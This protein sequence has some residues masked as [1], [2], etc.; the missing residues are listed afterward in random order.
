MVNEE[1]HSV[2]NIIQAILKA[3]KV[4]RMY[5]R[6]NPIYIKTL[7]ELTNRFSEFFDLN[8]CLKLNL[9]KNDIQF[10]TDCV[11]HKEDKYDNLA[12]LFFKDGLREL[13]FKRGLS[14]EEIEGFIN[15]I[16][17]DFD[18]D[19]IEDDIVTLLWEKDFENIRHVADDILLGD[20][21]DYEARAL[22]QVM[23]D[24]ESEPDL[25]KIYDDLAMV[26]EETEKDLSVFQS[27]DNDF[28]SFSAELEIDAR[29]KTPKLFHML[30]EIL[31]GLEMREEHQDIVDCFMKAIEFA[32]RQGNIHEV[33]D[34]QAKLKHLMF[35]SGIDEEAKIY[36]LKILQ[37]ASGHSIIDLIGNMLENG[38]KID[39]DAF[40]GY[41]SYLET[42]A[43]PPLLNILKELK[44]INAR[45]MIIEALASIGKKD[46]S[47]LI[48]GLN[49]PQWY[50]VRNVVHILRKIGDKQTV[51]YILKT[52]QH[53]DIRVKKEAIRTIGEL[54]GAD[55]LDTLK[56]CLDDA[57]IQIRKA[58][59]SA[60]G[61][62]GCQSAKKLLMERISGKDFRNRDFIEKKEY[63]EVLARWKENDVFDFLIDIL[64]R[65]ALWGRA[66]YLETKAG[67]AY[68][69]GLI[70]RKEAVAVLNSFRKAS[71]RLLREFS[72]TALKKIEDGI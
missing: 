18:K 59:L 17:Q 1:T 15:I 9:G 57:D 42:N 12:L 68:C 37:F 7:E 19:A 14:A 39:E 5:P 67:A 46:T 43:I 2:K 41:V 52:V 21:D 55:V 4:L 71:H 66:K 6:N 38:Q 51:K 11:Y 62:T 63:F 26:S 29:D 36:L 54:G 56:R 35:N 31:Y 34:V 65:R 49:D 30:F 20:K 28:R 3:K 69:L 23:Q 40:R 48:K 64:K 32:V 27:T 53:E 60:I 8:D 25:Q 24:N 45:K 13:T 33:V 44:T 50:V 72:F 61:I 47:A 10:N 16:S 70:G 22:K 58:S